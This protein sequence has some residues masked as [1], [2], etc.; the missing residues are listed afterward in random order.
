MSEFVG[1]RLA[2]PILEVWAAGGRL[3]S[4]ESVAFGLDWPLPPADGI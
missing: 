4:R 2:P 1:L 3:I